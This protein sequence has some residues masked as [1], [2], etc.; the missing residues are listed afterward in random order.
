MSDLPQRTPE[1]D[2]FL[3]RITGTI[4][5]GY[6][7]YPNG[8]KSFN[9]QRIGGDIIGISDALLEGADPEYLQRD[10][11]FIIAVSGFRAELIEHN[12]R[13]GCWLARHLPRQTDT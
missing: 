1:D 5:F 6:G 11:N 10:G 7:T 2:A 9:W 12:E 8:H 13:L 4:E 3:K